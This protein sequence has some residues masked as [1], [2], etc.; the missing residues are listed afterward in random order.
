VIA[1]L[2]R[3]VASFLRVCIEV[4]KLRRLAAALPGSDRRSELRWRRRHPP[5]AQQWPDQV[6]GELVFVG[7]A[8]IGEPVGVVETEGGDWLVRYADVQLG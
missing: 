6:G 3:E 4:E 7:E 8:L 1:R 2:P 5:C